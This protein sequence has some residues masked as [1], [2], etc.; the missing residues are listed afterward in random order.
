M[1]RNE[2]RPTFLESFS[3]VEIVVYLLGCFHDAV[4]SFDVFVGVCA[5][6]VWVVVVFCPKGF[7]FACF[8][9]GCG[10]VDGGV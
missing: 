3:V 8:V 6:W 5:F 2:F 7:S 9:F 4:S 1:E 10:D